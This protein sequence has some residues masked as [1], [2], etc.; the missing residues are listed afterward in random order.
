MLKTYTS[1]KGSSSGRTEQECERGTG[2]GTGRNPSWAA[3]RPV[4][5]PRTHLT[6]ACVRAQLSFWRRWW[7]MRIRQVQGTLEYSV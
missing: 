4:P 7:R 1:P 2:R 3:G 5:E 6:G